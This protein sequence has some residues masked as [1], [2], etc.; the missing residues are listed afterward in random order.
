MQYKIKC[1]ANKGRPGMSQLFENVRREKAPQRIFG[2]IRSLILKGKLMPGDKLP[3]EQK[4]TSHFGVSRQTLREALRALETQGLLQIRAGLGGGAFVTEVNLDTANANLTN[5]LHSRNPSIAHISEIRKNLEPFSARLAAERI[6]PKQLE[7]LQD[8]HDQG[9][10]AY[11]KGDYEQLCALGVEQH[12]AIAEAT[13]NPLLLLILDLVEKTLTRVKKTLN[14]D[15]E[16]SQHVITNHQAIISAI[17]ANDPDTAEKAM[18]HDVVV[19]EEQMLRLALKRG[20]DDSWLNDLH[21]QSLC[22][23]EEL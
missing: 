16:F 7:K 15:Q 17:T 20:K 22:R 5:F 23:A 11:E 9:L 1:H 10:A 13:G 6:Q 2:Q 14:I 12:R 18:H 4:L 19:V 8:L 3:S 21:M